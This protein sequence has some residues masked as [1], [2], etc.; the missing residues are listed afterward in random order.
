[1]CNCNQIDH[2][3]VQDDLILQNMFKLEEYY[4]IQNS[5]TQLV[6]SEHRSQLSIWMLEVCE[7]ENLTNE[8][9]YLS[10]SLFDR[11]VNSLAT[12]M[13]QIDQS[14]L[15]LFGTCC[16]FLAS[17][18]R[19]PAR[20][21]NSVRLV[22][23]TDNTIRLDELL[24]LE[25][26][27]L[28]RLRWDTDVISPNDYLEIF[29]HKL[30]LNKHKQVDLIK[31]HFYAFTALCSTETKFS[32]YP[33]SMLASSCLFAALEGLSDQL[34]LTQTNIRQI[35]LNLLN[36]LFK[37]GQIDPE[38]VLSL[39]EQINHLLNKSAPQTISSAKSSVQIEDDFDY[40]I[41]EY[42]EIESFLSSESSLISLNL[43]SNSLN[44]KSTR[45]STGSSSTE[46]SYYSQN[47]FLLTPPLAQTL[48]LPTF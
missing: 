26:L 10:M 40:N 1:M 12:T 33:S 9:F 15:Q 4:L 6:S 23:Y 7:E 32:F 16:L 36:I 24:E 20:S 45:S 29:L 39:K 38:C 31:R 46:I 30:G 14:Y 37:F 34:S 2:K 25:L 44:R 27:I 47:Y 5:N 28:E 18:I 13:Q 41:E 42:D 43:N 19:S 11:F 17:K 3:L 21:L 22:E 48:P 35:Q 8:I